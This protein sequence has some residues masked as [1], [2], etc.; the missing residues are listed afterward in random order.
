M[1]AFE[2]MLL[3]KR[4]TITSFVSIVI[5]KRL[6]IARLFNAAAFNYQRLWQLIESS[7][8]MSNFV[9]SFLTIK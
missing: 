1:E 3:V 9:F 6:T 4:Q 5:Y 7:N 8:L 2:V